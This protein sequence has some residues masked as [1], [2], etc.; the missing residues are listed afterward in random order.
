MHIWGGTLARWKHNLYELNQLR[1]QKIHRILDVAF[2]QHEGIEIPYSNGGSI[3]IEKILNDYDP[4]TGVLTVARLRS[5]GEI[6]VTPALCV[7]LAGLPTARP[8]QK[9]AIII[10]DN[11]IDLITKFVDDIETIVLGHS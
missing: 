5:W 3:L 10:L 6:L 7:T 1:N 4:K 11:Y 8:S 9:D 2:S